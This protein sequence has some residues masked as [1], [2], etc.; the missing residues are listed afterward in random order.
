MLS[1]FK[2]DV[3]P[4]GSAEARARAREVL[5][6]ALNKG[7]VPSWESY[8]SELPA[9]DSDDRAAVEQRFAEL[10]RW[11]FLPNLLRPD[12][13][14]VHFHAPELIQLQSSGGQ[15]ELRSVSLSD[16][17]WQLWLEIISLSFRQNWN[18]RH[19]F[20]SFYGSLF[21]SSYRLSL[22]HGSTS[23]DKRSKLVLRR[24][25]ETPFDLAA[26]GATDPLGELVRQKKNILIAGATGSGKTSL[27]ASLTSCFA[28][29]E[30][31]VVLEDTFEIFSG[32]RFLTRF[33]AG[34]TPETDLKAYLSY[35]LRLSPDRI[36]L[37]EMRSHEVIPF[38]LA[39]NT[40]HRGLMGT[41]HA[42]SAA[43]AINRI[44][45]LFSLYAG[46]GRLSFDRVTELVCRNLEYVVFMEQ[47]RVTEVIRILGADRGVPFFEA[48]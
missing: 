37:G 29:D 13:T 7:F 9:M 14:E 6:S 41:I 1:I 25:A 40:G 20:A 35:S 32:H 44:A 30:H 10:T 42:S 22:I 24:I 5:V 21:G 8:E 48:Y 45:L 3:T 43:D 18:V 39:M 38:L 4:L 12:C 47:R 19:P 33:L 23:P 27:L 34:P 46:D 28:P 31:V 26:F 11:T 16:A 15:R 36:I 17:D 2:E